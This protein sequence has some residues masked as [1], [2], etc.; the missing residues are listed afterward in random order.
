M[1]GTKAGGAAGLNPPPF[2]KSKFRP[3]G[4]FRRDMKILRD[5]HF[6]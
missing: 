4:F 1:G 2:S 5:L 3:A 6:S